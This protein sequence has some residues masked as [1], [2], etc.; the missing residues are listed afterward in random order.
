MS[1]CRFFLFARLESRTAQLVL[2]YRVLN[3]AR[4]HGHATGGEAPMPAG[5]GGQVHLAE[6]VHEGGVLGE[7]AANERR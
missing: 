5:V 7:P 6:D 3:E 1:L 2:L 4:D